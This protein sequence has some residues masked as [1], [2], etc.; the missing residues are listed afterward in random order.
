MAAVVL[1]GSLAARWGEDAQSGS[2]LVDR[3]LDA[4]HADRDIVVAELNRHL[5]V[6]DVD[7]TAVVTGLRAGHVPALHA[8]PVLARARGHVLG[9]HLVPARA[10]VPLS[11]DLVAAVVLTRDS[12]GPQGD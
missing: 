6:A 3:H 5:V 10:L 7:H 2:D 9:T 1:D 8:L 11:G 12:A 4:E